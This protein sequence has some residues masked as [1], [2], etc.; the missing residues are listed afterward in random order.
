MPAE[1]LPVLNDTLTDRFRRRIRYLRVSVT[2]RCNYRC[3]YCMP[4]EHWDRVPKHDV[5][6]LEELAF[7]VGVFAELGV[8]RVRLTGGEPLVRRDL[9]R[10]VADIARLPGIREVALTTN[11]HLLDRHAG[12][13]YAAGLRGLNVSIDTL[14]PDRFAKITRGGDLARVCAGLDA[15]RDA[16]F[17][18]VKVNAVAIR[19]F[20]D[21]E[22]ADLAAFC[23]ARDVVPRFIELMPI[24]DLDFQGPEH[25]L[26]TGDI[27]AR[28]AARFPLAPEEGAAGVTVRGPA[29]YHVVTEGP[30][31]GKKVGVISPMSDDGF[32]ETCNRARLTAR[33]GLRA[34]LANDDEVSVLQS[35]RGE[36]PREAL[37]RLIGEAVQGK[38]PAHRMRDP[39]AVPVSV[40]T[41]IGG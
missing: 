4:L 3:L 12:S 14:R 35:V 10:L 30:F 36:A 18:D 13:L 23:W 37:I 2:D 22:L 28:V 24:G 33:G 9:D 21:D 40:M 26:T 5:L 32:C 41:G 6:T 15:A 29:R 11:G 8:E 34:C 16:G 7:V 19:G 31:A 17:T 25:V 1:A 38:L 27:L 39:A 20:N